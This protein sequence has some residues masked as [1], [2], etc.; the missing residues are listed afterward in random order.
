MKKS[1]RKYKQI[2]ERKHESNKASYSTNM[3]IRI[4][5]KKNRIKRMEMMRKN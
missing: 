4:Q 5:E 3:L 2:T 1:L